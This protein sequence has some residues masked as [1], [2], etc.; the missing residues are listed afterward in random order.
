M[1]ATTSAMTR[2]DVT[3]LLRFL[4]SLL[5]SYFETS[6]AVV[7]GIPLDISVMNMPKTLLAIWNNPRPSAPNLLDKKMRKKNPNSLVMIEKIVTVATAL[8][9]DFIYLS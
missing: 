5:T 9:I 2:A 4:S 1:T 7:K 6:F 3:N 8:N